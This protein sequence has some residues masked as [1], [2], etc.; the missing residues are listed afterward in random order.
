MQVFISTHEN[1]EKGVIMPLLMKSDL[2]YV[3]SWTAVA[4]DDPKVAGYPD[5]VLLNRNE[6]NEVLA[7]INRFAI[8]HNFKQK[9]SGSRTERLIR[10]HLPD[11]VLS[12][13]NVNRWLLQNWEN[14]EEA[15]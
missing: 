14:F 5:S 11:D 2:K 10:E 15:K 4:P 3:Y 6:G 12:R 7:F 8:A 1:T 9:Q 13:R